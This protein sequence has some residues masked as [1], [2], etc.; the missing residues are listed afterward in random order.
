MVT[1]PEKRANR[2]YEVL[3]R[4]VSDV[5]FLELADSVNTVAISMKSGSDGKRFER[6]A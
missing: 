5:V 1:S 4:D 6:S 2:T 3:E